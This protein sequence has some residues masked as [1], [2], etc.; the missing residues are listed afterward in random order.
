MI[1]SDML[2]IRIRKLSEKSSASSR[3]PS[4]SSENPSAS[5]A[6][7]STSSAY[8]ST[9]IHNTIPERTPNREYES[10][11][12]MLNTILDNIKSIKDKLSDLTLSDYTL[13]D[14]N[15]SNVKII[16][17][18]EDNERKFR[19]SFDKLLNNIN[20]LVLIIINMYENIPNSNYLPYDMIINT[21]VLKLKVRHFRE[22]EKI[23]RN[24]VTS[25]ISDFVQSR[26][27]IEIINNMLVSTQA[28]KNG[29]YIKNKTIFK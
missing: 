5:I 9:S 3:N 6:Y 8:H 23:H 11:K 7:P 21:E 16:D 2:N 1:I 20:R 12:T 29:R 17:I 28:K 13:L 27:N 19:Y 4:A 14:T 22:M 10:M 24:K 15:L 26:Y 25:I 18:L